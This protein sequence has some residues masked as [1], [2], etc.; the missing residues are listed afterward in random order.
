VSLP[1]RLAPVPLAESP[2]SCDAVPVVLAHD[3]PDGA[4][5][6]TLP[7]LDAPALVLPVVD[8]LTLVPPVEALA[9]VL[10]TLPVDVTEVLVLPEVDPVVALVLADVPPAPAVMPAELVPPP[11]PAPAVTVAGPL[12]LALALDVAPLDGAVTAALAPPAE[13]LAPLVAADASADPLA[14]VSSLTV[15]VVVDPS[16]LALHE[17]VVV[18]AAEPPPAA[19]VPPL[20]ALALPDVEEPPERLPDVL[21]AATATEANASAPIAAN[22]ADQKSRDTRIASS[23]LFCGLRHCMSP[24]GSFHRGMV[25]VRA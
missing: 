21:T 12:T 11:L 16:V 7:E 25:R 1:V 4:L 8:P 10:G 22:P 18:A 19:L 17:S 15:A 9:D 6:V 2:A 3:V 23:S 5:V 14:L 24:H 13:A 20:T